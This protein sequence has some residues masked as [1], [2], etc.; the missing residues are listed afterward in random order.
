MGRMTIRL[1][2]V[3]DDPLVRAGLTFM[4]GGA[5]DIEI[6]GEAADGS[7]AAALTDLHRPDVVLMDIRMPVMDGLAATELLRGRPDA[8]EV[9]VLTTFHADEQVLRALRAGAAGFVLKDTPPAQ[10]VESV[11]RVA[12]GDPVLSP[13]VTRQL[14]SHVAESSAGPRRPTAARRIDGLAERE[15]EVAVAVGRGQSNAEIAATLYMSVPTVKTHVSRVLAKL[16]LN[17]R[18]QI[19]LLVHDAGL[20]DEGGDVG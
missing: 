16:G 3:D 13:A 18:V 14:M 4:L 15:R 8:P 10:I 6:V 11:R 17:N 20:L 5:D 7:E 19:A 9:V 2:I 12:A 1:L